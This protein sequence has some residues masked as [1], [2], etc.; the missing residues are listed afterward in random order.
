MVWFILVGSAL[1]HYGNEHIECRQQERGKALICFAFKEKIPLFE[2]LIKSEDSGFSTSVYAYIQANE[3]D[4]LKAD[5]DTLIR[6][7]KVLES[8]FPDGSSPERVQV[9][10]K[11]R[12]LSAIV[13]LCPFV[14]EGQKLEEFQEYFIN[15]GR[16]PKGIELLRDYRVDGTESLLEYYAR[17]RK[18][19]PW[20]ATESLKAIL[21]VYFENNI[22]ILS[23]DWN[24]IELDYDLRQ[25]IFT[26]VSSVKAAK[27]FL[28]RYRNSRGE[29]F[30]QLIMSADNFDESSLSKL[31]EKIEDDKEFLKLLND[32]A[33]G[34]EAAVRM[35]EKQGWG[36]D[37]LEN[38]DPSK[39][40]KVGPFGVTPLMRR[41]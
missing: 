19:D 35:I 41:A 9:E 12:D 17:K 32:A 30:T 13:H 8:E 34:A 26:Y 33:P 16:F 4:V 14:L 7:I 38:I 2:D 37:F 5:A 6:E 22:P 21:K 10:V 3:F 28:L 15:L 31:R 20:K 1:A 39:L 27:D 36:Q 29:N 24:I 11:K 25:F 23:S 40:V 18:T